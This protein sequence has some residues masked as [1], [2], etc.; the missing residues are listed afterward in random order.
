VDTALRFTH[1]GRMRRALADALG[2]R[3]RLLALEGAG[4]TFGAVHPMP[5]RGPPP[6]L[7]R[8]LEATLEHLSDPSGG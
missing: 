7:A 2:S 6:D 3:G 1:K 8:A 5:D 4:H